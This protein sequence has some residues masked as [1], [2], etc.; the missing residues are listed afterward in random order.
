MECLLVFLGAVWTGDGYLPRAYN[1]RATGQNRVVQKYEWSYDSMA[2][3]QSKGTL[4]TTS[5]GKTKVEVN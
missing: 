5:H 4:S 2:V 1:S 3:H